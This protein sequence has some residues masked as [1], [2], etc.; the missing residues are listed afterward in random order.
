MKIVSC[1]GCGILIDVDVR[2]FP[3]N[4]YDDEGTIDESKAMWYNRD[5][6]PFITC[7]VCKEQIPE[8][9]EC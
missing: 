2:Y 8:A 1:S 3:D 5:Y 7:P 6:V 9:Q 4:I